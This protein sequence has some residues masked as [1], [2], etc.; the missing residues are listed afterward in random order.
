MK[1]IVIILHDIIRIT[2]ARCK[3]LSKG[4]FMLE[5]FKKKINTLKKFG[6]CFC[7]H[8]C[9]LI[10]IVA[11]MLLVPNLLIQ[12]GG[13]I[14]SS[15]NLVLFY[16]LLWQIAM[17]LLIT[18]VYG[19][20][21]KTFFFKDL[22][23]S[24]LF[25]IF[26]GNNSLSRKSE[27]ELE[28]IW[29]RV[30]EC[31]YKTD[32]FADITDSIEKH[33]LEKYLPS[34]QPY[35]FKNYVSVLEF[36]INT[37]DSSYIDIIEEVQ[38]T[39]AGVD[40]EASNIVHKFTSTIDRNSGDELTSA[41]IID[42]R[43]NGKSLIIDD[44]QYLSPLNVSEE[45]SEKQLKI[46]CKLPLEEQ[47]E[48]YNLKIKTKQTGVLSINKLKKIGFNRFVKGLDVIIKYPTDKLAIEFHKVGILKDF[49][50]LC[51]NVN[52]MLCKKHSDVV[53]P[54]QGYLILIDSENNKQKK[55]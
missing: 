6:N 45:K 36:S 43:V 47:K 23:E 33:V 25:D 53:F 11:G 4:F 40:K 7:E 20:F 22:Y 24:K 14:P 49:D 46:I 52:G 38:F 18:G 5:F 30:S 13:V 3:N 1:L 37:N 48:E 21:S 41:K 35:Y 15:E 2:K 54:C 34:K 50:S 26:Y 29:K 9:A 12:I 44:Q 51:S 16:G 17:T 10:F 42:Y 19:I 28:S 55:E 8:K 27:A 31:M 32:R 39:L